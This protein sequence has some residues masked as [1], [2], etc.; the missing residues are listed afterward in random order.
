MPVG[1]PILHAESG[2]SVVAA[3][4]DPNNETYKKAIEMCD[5][6]GGVWGS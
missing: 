1:S 3:P 6:V 4:Q 5:K 2:M